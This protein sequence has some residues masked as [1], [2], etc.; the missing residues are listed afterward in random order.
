MNQSSS[1][2]SSMAILISGRGS[3]M[4]VLADRITSGD[5]PGSISFVGADREKA[6]GLEAARIRGLATQV[7]PYD[8][9][10][11][12][13]AE[14]QLI[15]AL[16]ESGSTWIV[17]A[18]F[19]KILSARFVAE[20]GGRI[21]NIHP[22]LLPAFPGV[23]A[24]GQALKYGVKITGVTVHLVDRKVDHGP[25]LAQRAVPVPDGTDRESLEKSI[26]AAEHDLYW[27]TL[28]DLFEG[29][30]VEHGRRRQLHEQAP[31]P[32]LGLE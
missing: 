25:I 31:R 4:S 27:R 11:R 2:L 15:Q 29:R 23:D 14:N 6:A 19:M 3:N 13:R 7:F 17:L 32:Y 20:F 18:G 10:G 24:I 30:Y 12:E 8:D 9:L 5:L 26:H 28:K 1:H 22:S 21:V 16:L